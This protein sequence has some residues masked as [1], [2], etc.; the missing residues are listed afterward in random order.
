MVKTLTSRQQ[1]AI[2]TKNRIYKTAMALFEKYG[3]NN[4]T[5]RD[6][7][8]ACQV[9]TGAFY[10]YFDNK[11]DILIEQYRI[12]DTAF[13]IDTAALAGD[14]YVEK[15]IVYMGLFADKAELAGVAAVT[16]I[17]HA[18]LSRR[19]GF[20]YGVNSALQRGLAQLLDNAAKA[21]EIPPSLNTKEFILDIVMLARGAI[22]HW[23]LMQGSFP[24]A[25]KTRE[26]IRP[27][28]HGKISGTHS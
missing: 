27:Y 3:F 25:D 28:L 9:S 4:V 5:L 6:I 19:L 7:C 14:S 2:E 22:Y 15:I 20:P 8:E 1:Q 21:G 23:C 17:C 18:G 16:E 24:L 12:N 26:I 10:H 13:L 11:D